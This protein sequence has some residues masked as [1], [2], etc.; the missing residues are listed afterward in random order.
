MKKRVL[1]I[2]NG[3][4]GGGA[5]R[6]LQTIFK[7]LDPNQY[8]LTLYSLHKEEL[9][10]NYPQHI[11]YNYIFD[12]GS[13]TSSFFKQFIIRLK[14]KIKLIIYN[15]FSPSFFYKLFISGEYDTEVAFIEGYATKIIS[16][17]PNKKSK[18]LAWVHIDLIQNHWTEIAFNNQTEE[19]NCYKKFDQVLCVSDS[20][21]SS[22]MKLF[23]DIPNVDVCYNPINDQRIRELANQPCSF[24]KWLDSELAMVTMGR[25]VEQK[26][27]DR[28]L[29]IVY[30]LKEDGFKFTLNILGEGKDRN[31]LENYIKEHHL[32]DTVS[33]IGY[34]ENPYPYLKKGDLFVCSSRS[35]GYSTVVT[36]ALILGLPV[37]T[38]ECA[39][40][41]ELLDN[42]KYGIITENSEEELYYGLKKLLESNNQISEYKKL[43]KT[44]GEYFSL[45]NLMKPIEKILSN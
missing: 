44:R 28:L 42:G 23:K 19:N 18:K 3:L 38:T 12:H 24:N 4:Y 40:M 21:R 32:E 43:A 14:N 13:N 33:L 8:D 41:K 27:Y 31:I 25:L 20:V 10:S 35:E 17:S 34:C 7:N 36:E 6:I 39:G 11:K 26:G 2:N 22:F 15:H 37:I 5:E 1:F 29:P 30:K 45:K 9:D 16:G